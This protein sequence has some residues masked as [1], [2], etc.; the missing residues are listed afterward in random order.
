M[1]D[2]VPLVP[3][4]VDRSYLPDPGVIRIPVRIGQARVMV[5]VEGWTI[6]TPQSVVFTVAARIAD[7][8]E[9][10]P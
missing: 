8:L 7:A 3:M 2:K 4:V 1:P 6:P 10:K 9:G 5:Y